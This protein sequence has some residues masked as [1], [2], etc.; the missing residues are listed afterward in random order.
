[1]KNKSTVNGGLREENGFL[2]WCV[3]GEEKGNDKSLG[4]KFS[5]TWHFC[6]GI[7]A[8]VLGPC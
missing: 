4:G 6:K 3:H 2:S 7:T 5:S 1:M 8:A